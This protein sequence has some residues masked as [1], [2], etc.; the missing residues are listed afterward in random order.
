MEGEA[1]WMEKHNGGR[2]AMEAEHDG[3]E[4]TMEGVSVINGETRWRVGA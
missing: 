2:S 3:G 1:Q 4:S